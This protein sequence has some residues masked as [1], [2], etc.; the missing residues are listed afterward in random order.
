MSVESADEN[1]ERK[2]EETKP[3]VHSKAAVEGT[4]RELVFTFRDCETARMTVC[5][6]VCTDITQPRSQHT[7]RVSVSTVRAFTK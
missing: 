7:M 1:F 6:S 5:D 3:M 4:F 2:R